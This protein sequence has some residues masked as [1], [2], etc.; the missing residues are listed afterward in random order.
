MVNVHDNRVCRKCG[1]ELSID[2]FPSNG[3]K[4]EGYRYQCKECM[5]DINRSWRLKKRQVKEKGDQ[6]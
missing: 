6:I 1:R 2:A 4:R 5:R 3:A